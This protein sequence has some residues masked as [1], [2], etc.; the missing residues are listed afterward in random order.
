MKRSCFVTMKT[1][2]YIVIHSIP[3]HRGREDFIICGYASSKAAYDHADRL[4]DPV[5]DTYGHVEEVTIVTH[6]TCSTQTA[7]D[8]AETYETVGTWRRG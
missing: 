4:Y 5:C 3:T 8:I 7:D 1:K 2:V 6:D